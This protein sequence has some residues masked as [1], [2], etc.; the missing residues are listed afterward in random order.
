MIYFIGILDSLVDTLKVIAIASAIIS[1]MCGLV[2]AMQADMGRDTDILRRFC[3]GG[4]ASS[5]VCMFLMT[6]TPSSKLAA[7]MYVVP[8][9]ANNENVQAIGC[10]GLEALRKLTED[11]LRELNGEKK[12]QDKDSKI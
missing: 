11:W 12:P 2:W 1:F 8:A 3:L 5:I 7:A 10:N 4:M 9:I 6:F